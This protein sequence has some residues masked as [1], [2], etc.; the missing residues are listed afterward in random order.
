MTRDNIDDPEVARY[1]YLADCDDYELSNATPTAA[2]GGD[3]AT[4]ATPSS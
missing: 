4:A 1:L 2:M 3:S